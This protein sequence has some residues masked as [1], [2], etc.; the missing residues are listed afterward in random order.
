MN[1]DLFDG[2]QELPNDNL[3]EI[4]DSLIGFSPRYKT[5]KNYFLLNIEPK[6]LFDWSEKYYGKIIPL[7]NV[8]LQKYPLFIFSGDIGTG[9]T[10]TAQCVADQLSRD[11]NKEGYLLKLS[12][13]VR[14]SGLHGEMSQ[15]IHD[16]FQELKNLA[17]KKRLAF[18]LIDEADSIASIRS[19]E[20]MHQEEKASVN[21][22]IQ[23]IDEIRQTGGRAAIFMCT[24]RFRVI[25]Q[26]VTRRAALHMQFERPS[27]SELLEL[28][29]IDFSGL[30]LTSDQ[31]RDLSQMMGA[32]GFHGDVGYTFS[33]FRLRYLPEIVARAYPDHC[34]TFDLLKETAK[35]VRPSAELAP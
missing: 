5:F 32:G 35:D 26:A 21:T 23:N 15:L 14:G 2:I 31:L 8:I 1:I 22:L 12:T 29:E 24:N 34:L 4:G 9:K 16:A 18:L 11:L 30:N 28:F 19:I 10:V 25:D 27:Q 3:Q 20:Q 33:D 6:V 7:C 13:R 17:G